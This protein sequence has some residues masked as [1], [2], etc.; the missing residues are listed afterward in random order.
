MAI[1]AGIYGQIQQPQG[2]NQL[3]SLGQVYQIQN[4]DQQNRLGM[5]QLGEATRK[6]QEDQAFNKLYESAI[7]PDG[8][9][10]QQALI[11][12][13]AQGGLGARIP[14]LQKSLAESSKASTEAEAQKFK[15]AHERGQ[16]TLNAI[17]GAR[18]QASYDA[19]RADIQALGGDVSRMPAQYD[20]AF[21]Q[22]AGQRV[23]TEQQRIE[24][25][26]RQKGFSVTMR[27][28]DIGRQNSIDT[29][30]TSRANNAASVGAT[31]RGQNMTDSRQR[32][33]NQNGRVPTGY[34]QLAD[35][36]L[37]FIPG[38]PADPASAKKASPTEFQGKSAIFGARAQESNRILNDLQGTYSPSAINA[39]QSLGNVWGVGGALESGAN[40]ILP[41]NTQ[42]AEQARRDFVNAVLRQESGA[43]IGKD[44]FDNASRQY[45]PQPGDSAAVIKQKA[46]NRALQ[47]QGLL[48]NAGNA[49]IPSRPKASQGGS[50]GGW[51]IEEVK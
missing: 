48:G 5:L 23:L 27:G 1:S 25:A 41:A 40:S 3:A 34:R 10:D 9:I 26:A 35:G 46:D 20:P 47:I 43:A 7:K 24:E 50:T 31:I 42:R 32:E 15:L 11:T 22:N 21:V 8:T 16:A 13:A 37:E 45:F 30:A 29:N 33:S 14:G 36:S 51:A 17:S 49:P 12:G 19:A 2:L 44:E 18:D 38:G 39:K 4:A 28:Q 6:A